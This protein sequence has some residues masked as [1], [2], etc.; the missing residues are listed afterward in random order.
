MNFIK[1]Y[2]GFKKEMYILFIG[3]IANTMGQV[4]WPTM[5]LVLANKLGYNASRIASLQL[6]MLILQLPFAYLGGKLAD[7]AN[8]KT[9]IVICD[10]CVAICFFACG[11]L[12]ISIASVWVFF[13][14]GTFAIVELPCYDALV[15][16]LARPSE[17]ERAYS[18][19]Y[20]GMNLGYVIAPALSGILFENHLNLFYFVCAVSTLFAS[21]L[22]WFMVKQISIEPGSQLL[23]YEIAQDNASCWSVLKNNRVIL[24]FIFLYSLSQF[25]YNDFFFLVPINMESLY[26]ARGAVYYGYMNSINGVVVITMTAVMVR[27]FSRWNNFSKIVTG[28]ALIIVGLS[29]FIFAEHALWLCFAS[30]VVFTLGEILTT[31]SKQPFIIARI[32]ATH[33]GRVF[34]VMNV[35]STLLRAVL[36]IP[37]GTLA[38][39]WPMSAVW[40]SVTAV[41]MV[42]LVL[43]LLLMK[44]DK[45]VFGTLW[46]K[47]I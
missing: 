12:P 10:L 45:K 38:D 28:E 6:V 3:R 41:G 33:R 30:V 36:Q 24:Y 8:K 7:K 16:D 42:S 25:I 2:A 4:V 34:A 11:V 47:D 21:S 26:G 15:A 17:R 14:A 19:S 37:F 43:Y 29:I 23:D 5:T 20:L 32:P 27:I 46:Q 1:Q 13:A 40:I 35:S 18:L 44:K 22:I 39:I 9:C 31:V